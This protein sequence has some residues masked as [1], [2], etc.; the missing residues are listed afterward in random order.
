LALEQRID[1]LDVAVA[2]QP[3]HVG[4]LLADQVVDDHLRAVELVGRHRS[5]SISGR[6]P[7]PKAPGSYVSYCCTSIDN[8]VDGPQP[9]FSAE[10]ASRAT[11]SGP[12][13]QRRGGGA[14]VPL[15]FGGAGG[16]GGG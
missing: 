6:R 4:R 14:V 1:E 5:V 2:A 15:F 8:M 13:Q 12:P 16:E 9:Q 11:K 10:T 3:E 7:A